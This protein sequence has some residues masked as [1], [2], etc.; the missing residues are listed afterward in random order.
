MN[1]DNGYTFSVK[2]KSFS[3]LSFENKGDNNVSIYCSVD[4]DGLY[5]T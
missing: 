3:K 5:L 2:A 4:L 1:V